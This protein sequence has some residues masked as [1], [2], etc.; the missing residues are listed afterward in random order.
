MRLELSRP[1]VRVYRPALSTP[2]PAEQQFPDEQLP[3]SLFRAH[4]SEAKVVRTEVA[5]AR[6]GRS[7]QH[8]RGLSRRAIMDLHEHWQAPC[9]EMFD[10]LATQYPAD[11]LRMIGG[12]GLD[13]VE[14]TWAVERVGHVVDHAAARAALVPLLAHP[15]P[16]VR[17]GAV[18]SLDRHLDDQARV[19]LEQLARAD[20]SEEVRKAATDA[21][22]GL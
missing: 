10:F 14:L 8:L 21:L 3:E 9:E 2:F 15:H 11:L 18:Y 16:M 5:F 22:T 6:A 4:S 13:A 20:P 1:E 12:G 17:E 19:R 7:P